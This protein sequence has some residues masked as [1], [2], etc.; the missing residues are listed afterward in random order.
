VAIAEESQ[1]V[2]VLALRKLFCL[3][4]GYAMI[5]SVMDD[6]GMGYTQPHPSC[7]AIYRRRP[8]ELPQNRVLSG[9]AAQQNFSI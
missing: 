2:E 7:R 3:G 1:I 9:C 8:K 5:I 6:F 4:N